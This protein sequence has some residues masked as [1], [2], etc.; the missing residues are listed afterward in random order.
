MRAEHYGVDNFSLPTR[1]IGLIAVLTALS[2]AT[3]YAIIG[4]PNVKL[5]DSLVFIGAFLFGLEVGLG[6]AVSIWS[7]YGFINPWGQDSIPLLFFL[8]IGECFYAFAGKLAGR[9]SS[10]QRL[11]SDPTFG[12]RLK[13]IFLFGLIGFL[14]T[15]AYDVLTNFGSW[16]FRTSTLYQALTIGMI[17]GVPFAI[18]HEGSNLFFFGLVVPL[19]I[20]AS[21]R[22]GLTSRP[23]N[24]G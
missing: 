18:L 13:T 7:V 22:T 14:P 16:V 9:A 3:N 11:L 8:V 2:L 20:I 4:I 12:S 21:R 24:E 5:M 23:V 15:F 6:S 10:V 1:K 19:T 17:T